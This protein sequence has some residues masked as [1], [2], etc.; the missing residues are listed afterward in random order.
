MKTPRCGP[1]PR[2]SARPLDLLGF[3]QSFQPRIARKTWR[4]YKRSREITINAANATHRHNSALHAVFTAFKSADTAA[5][6][7][8]ALRLG[9]R[10]DGTPGSRA[11]ALTRYAHV[12][13]GRL[14]PRVPCLMYATYVIK[15]NA[16][17]ST[18]KALWP[19]A[20]HR[21]PRGCATH[22]AVTGCMP[23]LGGSRYAR[24]RAVHGCG[25]R[26]RVRVHT[27]ERTIYRA[28]SL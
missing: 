11:D 12:N 13:S 21:A 17:F 8:S 26:V 20:R 14:Q 4:L 5:A 19:L 2:P 10:G 23:R 28:P 3:W 25:V 27:D 7:A 1:L 16:Q 24:G 22:R 9:D 18:E 6:P 15:V